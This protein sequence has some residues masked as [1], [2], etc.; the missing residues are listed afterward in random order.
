DPVSAQGVLDHLQHTQGAAYAVLLRTNGSELA[1]WGER[2]Q[3]AALAADGGAATL[4][5]DGLLHVR[6]PFSTRSGHQGTLLVGYRLD[7][8]EA[9]RRETHRFVAEAC[10]AVLTVGLLATFL[11]GTLLVRPLQKIAAVARRIADGDVAAEADLPLS[12]SDEAGAVARALAL[13]L[14][15]LYR[16]QATIE[17]LAAGL[18]RRVAERTE[19]L[20]TAN[21]ELANSLA[22]LKRTQEQLIIA[23]RRVAIGRLAAGV[24]HEI[25]NPLSFIK[26]NLRFALDELSRLTADGSRKPSP[27]GLAELREALADSHEGTERVHHIVRG[28]KA[29]ARADDEQKVR[30]KVENALAAAIDMSAHELRQRAQIIREI[31]AAPE[32]EGN[33]V[34]L[35]QVFLNLL[36]NAGQAIPEGKTGV[37]RV[38]LATDPRGWALVEVTD[39]GTGIKQE[40]LSRIF[41]PFFTT[42][43]V[44]VGTGLGLSISQGIVLAMGG[45]I[46]VES[47]E[48]VGTTFRVAL[49]PS[50]S[51]T[52]EKPPPVFA[53][54]PRKSRRRLL[55]IDDEPLVGTAVRRTLAREHEVVLASSGREALDLILAGE[56]FDHILCD[57]MMPEMSGMD[58]QQE[59]SRAAPHLMATLIF[60][61]GGAFTDGARDFVS[62]NP[63]LEK[64]LNIEKL[65]RIVDA[66][67]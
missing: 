31:G 38:R 36:L 48:G 49:P 44:G 61:T 16:H 25:N 56:R 23:D 13:M 46:G 63:V 66:H 15:R 7:D 22:E 17:A 5:R 18:E 6:V 11:I 40:H 62:R 12:R 45:E 29:F 27:Q 53:S 41:D 67:P 50:S 34:R 30:V 51:T 26:A 14:E 33:E 54:A 2:A 47:R 64:P 28:L 10:A 19:Q 32:V 4:Y 57:L 37:V 60:M 21:R 39:T 58:F 43:P 42:K 8:L 24:A 1:A 55:V 65:R 35:S 59:L 20:E 52:S 9:R 3:G